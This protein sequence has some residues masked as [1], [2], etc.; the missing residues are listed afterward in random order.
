MTILTPPKGMSSAT[1]SQ[2]MNAIKNG[3]SVENFPAVKNSNVAPKISQ[4]NF[5]LAPEKTLLQSSNLAVQNNH[6]VT[7]IC[8]QGPGN[9]SKGPSVTAYAKAGQPLDFNM[10][11][12]PERI[13]VGGGGGGAGAG[14]PMLTKFGAN[15]RSVLSQQFSLASISPALPGKASTSASEPE[16]PPAEFS[17]S[18]CYGRIR[19]PD[20]ALDKH[21]IEPQFTAGFQVIHSF[22]CNQN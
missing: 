4:Q 3:T 7:G 17:I 13:K 6:N 10:L 1:V 18:Q 21:A 19:M 11:T 22:F 5:S 2:L 9:L 16:L 8:S 12:V 15:Q 20:W 14:T